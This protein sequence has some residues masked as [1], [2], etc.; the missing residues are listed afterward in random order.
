MIMLARSSE[1]IFNPMHYTGTFDGEVV[2]CHCT[3][4]TIFPYK[5]DAFDGEA[6]TY[7]CTTPELYIV[8]R[9]NCEKFCCTRVHQ[10][11]I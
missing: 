3:Y 10:C 9:I 11:H 2:T 7:F 5:G 4:L 1:R 8:N 6:A